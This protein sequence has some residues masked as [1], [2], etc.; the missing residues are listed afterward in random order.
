VSRS[1]RK[2]YAALRYALYL[3]GAFGKAYAV[4]DDLILRQGDSFESGNLHILCAELALRVKNDTCKARQL[5]DKAHQIGSIDLARYYEVQGRVCCRMGNRDEAIQYLENSIALDPAAGKLITLGLWLSYLDDKRAMDV[6]KDVLSRDPKNSIARIYAGQEAAKSGDRDKAL[7]MAE[8]SKALHPSAEDVFEIGQLYDILKLPQKALNEYLHSMELGYKDKSSL[9]AAISGCYVLLA[10]FGA[11]LRYAA[12]ALKVDPYADSVKDI[13]LWS[14]EKEGMNSTLKRLAKRHRN[15]SLAFILFAQEAVKQKNF[16]MA[17]EMLHKAES[18][19]L[20]ATE[21]F[22]VGRLYANLG[23]FERA[24]EVLLECNRLGY[25]NKDVL[26]EAIA[27]C[28]FS[29]G[30][31]DAAIRYAIRVLALDPDEDSAKDLLHSCR[32]ALWGSDFG[33]N[34]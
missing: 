1:V 4:L 34:Y 28:Y 32:E 6:W 8:S 19:P 33:D 27:Q 17:S 23:N 30:D 18:C 2:I 21:M 12:R 26:Y 9:F 11:A 5:L 24:V 25:D 3:K 15:T 16:T 20:S 31:Y 10:D 14:A 29:L 7:L 22:Y 13:L